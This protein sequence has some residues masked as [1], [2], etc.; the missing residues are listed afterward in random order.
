MLVE[1]VIKFPFPDWICDKFTREHKLYKTPYCVCYQQIIANNDYGPYG[2]STEKS[3][4]I[5][6]NSFGS[7]FY[8][9]DKKETIRKCD[10]INYDGIYLYGAEIEGL[11]KEYN[12][13]FA[14]KLKNNI[15][16]KK[17]LMAEPVG[18]EPILYHVIKNNTFDTGKVN[19]L[20]DR[21]CG[22]FLSKFNMPE[23]GQ[24]L[25]IFDSKIWS[26]IKLASVKEGVDSLE[27]NSPN[28]LRAW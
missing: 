7:I 1:R 14:L 24:I 4:K 15:K 10:S 3:L 26:N 18:H 2:F 9:D 17:G 13:Y 20:S 27:L 5:I 11:I 23:G 6:R 28:E 21:G 12:N 19:T 8:V 16:I 25:F 22:F